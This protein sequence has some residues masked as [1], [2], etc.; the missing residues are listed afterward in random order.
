M[1]FSNDY[2]KKLQKEQKIRYKQNFKKKPTEFRSSTEMQVEAMLSLKPEHS[3]STE[4]R[5]QL[6]KFNGDLMRHC[7]ASGVAS[8]QPGKD[9]SIQ[10][11]V[12]RMVKML[13][14]YDRYFELVGSG[15]GDG[16][17]KCDSL[18]QLITCTMIRW[19]SVETHDLKLVQELFSL[20][21]RQFDEVGEVVQA[22]KNTYV[23][24]VTEDSNTGKPNFDI[25]GFCYALGSLRLLL[26]VGMGT[27]EEDLLKN[28]LKYVCIHLQDTF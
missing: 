9:L 2:V 7:G 20:L 22:L 14:K 18:R 11:K 8:I 1:S 21:Y 24:E 28:S 15:N 16:A 27:E 5:P 19:A 25:P 12:K 4:L 17:A 23:L 6:E 10:E 3:Y 13:S 26:S